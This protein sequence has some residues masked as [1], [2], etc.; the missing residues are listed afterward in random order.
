MTPL[1]IVKHLYIINDTSCCRTR[2]LYVSQN[3]NA[4]NAIRE[5]QVSEVRDSEMGEDRVLF[6]SY[7][8]SKVAQLCAGRI[9]CAIISNCVAPAVLG[10][11][12]HQLLHRASQYGQFFQQVH[13]LT[14]S[15]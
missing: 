2:V 8:I 12:R 10:N 11:V 3:T 7:M 15:G 14:T 5:V 13:V 1:T 4:T 6:N 9:S